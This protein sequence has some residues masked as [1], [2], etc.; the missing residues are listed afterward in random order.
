ML[1]IALAAFPGS[2]LSGALDEQTLPYL[3]RQARL[4]VARD[5][6]LA[7]D[8]H[9]VYTL[10]I[11]PQGN[12]DS[13]ADPRI[14]KDERARNVLQRC[15]H[16]ARSR[17]LL[18]VANGKRTGELTPRPSGL[19]YSSRFDLATIPFVPKDVLEQIGPRFA[20]AK[21]HR[22]MAIDVFGLVGVAAGAGSPE[23]ASARALES[24]QKN[25]GGKLCFPYALDD[26]VIFDRST[27][28]Y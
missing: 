18:V 16:R 28:I 6:G 14:S 21:P 13:I 10:A 27:K 19:T 11:A 20:A 26:K 24:C 5:F 25:S 22:A 9:A 12:W 7:G 17:C 2:A 1:I 23:E 4:N 8:N 15:E 3:S